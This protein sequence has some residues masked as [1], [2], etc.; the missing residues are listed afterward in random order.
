MHPPASGPVPLLP[1]DAPMIQQIDL[2]VLSRLVL[3]RW[4]M[5]LPLVLDGQAIL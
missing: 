5:G 3:P 4:L 2:A 1:G